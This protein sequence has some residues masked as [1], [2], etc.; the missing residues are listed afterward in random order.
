MKVDTIHIAI[1]DKD[2]SICATNI[3]E[4]S[5]QTFALIR[6]VM[7]YE[8][9]NNN[10]SI[11]HA[12]AIEI[13]NKGW[14]ITGKRGCGKT[15]TIL[16]LIKEKAIFIANDRVFIGTNINKIIAVPRPGVMRIGMGTALQHNEISS[17]VP[18][19]YKKIPAEQL[20]DYHLPK[21]NISFLPEIMK[22]RYKSH[23]I[24]EGIIFPQICKKFILRDLDNKTSKKLL[25][26][27]ILN[28]FPGLLMGNLL[29]GPY[30]MNHNFVLSSLSEYGT[31]FIEF[32][33]NLYKYL[34]NALV[35]R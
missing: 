5:L 27:S 7:E 17:M 4:L 19:K 14:I 34:Y 33:S 13:N 31:K 1:R 6:A 32:G 35:I 11:F 21:I 30:P 23:T 3:K 9:L 12:G 15:S 28:D 24:I 2:I 16:G 25:N 22:C 29:F 8:Y 18:K 26:D 20:F 10:F